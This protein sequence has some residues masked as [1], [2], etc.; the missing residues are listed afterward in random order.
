MPDRTILTQIGSIRPFSDIAGRHILHFDGSAESRHS[1][2]SRLEAV[3][4]A[5]IRSGQDWLRAG[6][7]SLPPFQPPPDAA[8]SAKPRA[9]AEVRR[10]PNDR[11]IVML[12][13]LAGVVPEPVLICWHS[14][15]SEARVYSEDIAS[16]FRAAGWPAEHRTAV[17]AADVEGIGI[18]FYADD[19]HKVTLPT[20][21]ERIVGAFKAAGVGLT[22]RCT[23]DPGLRSSLVVAVGRRQDLFF[24]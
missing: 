21:V 10:I 13:E 22:V 15:D 2:A 18:F 14:G 6:D 16:V 24:A 11:K 17:A 4:C 3:G 1:L 19:C 8:A 9:E 20:G 7:F 5:V 23:N 12:N